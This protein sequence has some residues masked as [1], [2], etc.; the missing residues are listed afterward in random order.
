MFKS[1]QGE[2]ENHQFKK[3][4]FEK[5]RVRSEGEKGIQVIV[6]RRREVL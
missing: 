3:E 5:S 2:T 4:T 6:R 1:K